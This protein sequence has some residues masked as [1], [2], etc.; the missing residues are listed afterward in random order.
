MTFAVAQAA[1]IPTVPQISVGTLTN[2]SITITLTTTSTEP[3]YGI[4]AYYV[5]RSTDGVTWPMT[6]T[7]VLSQTSFPYIDTGLTVGTT[8]SYRVQAAGNSTNRYLS[9][10]STIKSGT[11]TG[12][13]GGGGNTLLNYIQSLVG[14]GKMLIGQTVDWYNSGGT[15]QMTSVFT[16]ASPDY[17]VPGTGSMT[18]VVNW[19][20]LTAT[21]NNS[22]NFFYQGS[23]SEIKAHIAKN[24]IVQF[25][26]NFD[27]PAGWRA[28][29]GGG[30]Y[31]NPPGTYGGDGGAYDGISNP[32]PM[33]GVTLGFANGSNQNGGYWIQS[34][35]PTSDSIFNNVN[36]DGSI[37]GPLN[38]FQQRLI[39]EFDAAAAFFAQLV[40]P[41]GTPLPF[42]FAPFG[43]AQ[44]SN[45]WWNCENPFNKT[46]FD[47]SNS[48]NVPVM[49]KAQFQLLYKMCVHEISVVK[50]INAIWMMETGTVF[51]PQNSVDSITACYP[52]PTYAQLV[53]ADIN[54]FPVFPDNS[55]VGNLS[56]SGNSVKNQFATCVTAGATL[57]GGASVG[58]QGSNNNY[59]DVF[60]QILNTGSPPGGQVAGF[61]LGW[62]AG[63]WFAQNEALNVNAGAAQIFADTRAISRSQTPSYLATCPSK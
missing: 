47:S 36:S 13:G 57:F 58:P 2:T 44:G 48:A 23:I 11:T 4:F 49:T 6:P 24:G 34:G 16:G 35:T 43:E 30:S 37:T 31:A 25:T 10:Y 17:T 41:T 21:A 3:V 7:V 20:T 45:Q 61:G 9:N 59:T 56:G 28:P 19:M 14:T 52:G 33:T 1:A 29:Q 63:V 55:N 40:S 42:I 8:Y 62:T 5:Y 50:G 26:G 18:A 38:L 53:G 12:G 15:G 39:A 51:V 32:N 22:P 46:T 60:Q 27:N 54:G